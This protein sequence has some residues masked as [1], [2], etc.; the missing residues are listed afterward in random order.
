MSTD[1]LS[2]LMT[3]ARE[4]A[5][6]ADPSEDELAR[7]WSLTASDLA[8]IIR[9]RGDDHRRRF[10][11]QLCMLR[12]HGRFLDDYRR[13]PIKIV[14][15]LS[16]QLNLAPVLYLDPPGRQQTERAQALRIRRHL[17]LRSAWARSVCS[18]PGGS[19]YRTGARLSWRDR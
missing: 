10:A 13:A 19:R 15:H 4:R 18:R 16:R 14:N 9:C 5:A 6:P 1:D 2:P 8:E 11:L 7:H 12:A 17:G 3:P